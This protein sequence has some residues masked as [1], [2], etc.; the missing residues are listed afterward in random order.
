MGHTDFV[1]AL[2]TLE[3]PGI[4]SPILISGGAESEILFWNTSTGAR[5]HVLKGHLR[6]ILDLKWD[7]MTIFPGSSCAILYTASSSREIRACGIPLTGSSSTTI[8]TITSDLKLKHLELSQPLNVH[9]TSVYAMHFDS[10]GDLWTASADKTAK[11]LAR[12][13]SQD[14]G[15]SAAALE[16]LE[17]QSE[18]QI[19]TILSHPDFVRAIVSHP[20]FGWVITGC[21]DEEVR[22][23]NA[24]TGRLEHTYTGHYE[25]VTG[26]TIRGTTVVSV[27]IDGTVR[28]WGLSKQVIQAARRQAEESKVGFG[29]EKQSTEK[30]GG[31]RLTE[32]EERELAEL[33]DED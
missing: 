33:M 27:S 2:E 17:P 13:V 9:E 10:D 4:S 11:H 15:S 8:E 1:K 31:V 7:P 20:T 14:G 24:A 21:R 25:E 29:P 12:I 22:V 26:L 23:W 28:T 6:G 16:S 30:E 19:D 32:E 5:L 18:W 3:L